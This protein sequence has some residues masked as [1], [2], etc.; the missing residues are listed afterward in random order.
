MWHIFYTARNH[1]NCFAYLMAKLVP[2]AKFES[3][4]RLV[5]AVKS[6]SKFMSEGALSPKYIFAAPRDSSRSLSVKSEENFPKRL[7]G[8]HNS[9][10]SL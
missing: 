8:R 3:V 2:W 6:D 4:N 1:I 5:I 10:L 7:W 9:Q